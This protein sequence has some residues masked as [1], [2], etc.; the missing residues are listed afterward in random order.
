M[1]DL[2]SF[3]RQP[4][5]G[6]SA[7]RQEEDQYQRPGECYQTKDDE[8]PAPFSNFV[9]YVTNFVTCDTANDA[10]QT[11]SGKPDAMTRSML[12]WLVP[13]TR[14]QA[15]TWIDDAFESAEKDSESK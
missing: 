10:C 14:D 2:S 11:V 4:S 8:D 9:V 13:D 6:E 7:V 5:S 1:G 15:E 12:T 3:R